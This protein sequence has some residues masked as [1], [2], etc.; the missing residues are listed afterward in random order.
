MNHVEHFQNIES[1]GQIIKMEPV[2]ILL[3]PLWKEPKKDCYLVLF[4]KV[5][6]ILSVGK[7]M[8]SFTYE[9]CLIKN[10][11]FFKFYLFNAGN[12]KIRER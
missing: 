7:E 4:P 11:K 12:D 10:V 6:M 9:V 3:L 5:L 8:T 1:Y 2:T